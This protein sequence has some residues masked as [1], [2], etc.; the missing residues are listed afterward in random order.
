M[1][2]LNYINFIDTDEKD[3]DLIAPLW[4]KLKEH[5]T[6]RA[7]EVFK[8]QF[9]SMT[10]QERRQDLLRKSRNGFMLVS[11]VKDRS[12]DTLLGYCVS[13]I[14]ENKTGEVESIYVEKGHR[15]RGIGEKLMERALAWFDDHAVDRKV[16]AVAG[17]NEE[18]F[19][20]YRKYGFYP[21]VTILT[22]GEKR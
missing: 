12:T 8:E 18:V 15:R 1:E 20:F 21:R 11:L 7:H 13:T 19:P 2:N 10:F 9:G 6:N 16:I 5:H 17:G 4:E 3:L 14:S 22:K